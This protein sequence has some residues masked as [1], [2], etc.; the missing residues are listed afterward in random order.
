MSR[1]WNFWTVLLAAAIFSLISLW[2]TLALPAVPPTD[3]VPPATAELAALGRRSASLARMLRVDEERLR[4]D[5]GAL[6]VRDQLIRVRDDAFGIF[7]RLR[8]L[9]QEG[10]LRRGGLSLAEVLARQLSTLI[11]HVRQDIAVA[12]SLAVIED[13]ASRGQGILTGVR[14]PRPPIDVTKAEQGR[15]GALPNQVQTACRSPR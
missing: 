11:E 3:A 15:S 5:C 7:Q 2:S 9:G 12:D 4:S 10:R 1:D 13:E 8:E 6:E 14:I